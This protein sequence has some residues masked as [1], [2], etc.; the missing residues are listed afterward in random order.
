MKCSWLQIQH[1]IYEVGSKRGGSH[2]FYSP[3]GQQTTPPASSRHYLG[4]ETTVQLYQLLYGWVISRWHFFLKCKVLSHFTIISRR[5]EV[6]SLKYCI[7]ISLHRLEVAKKT[8][9][10]IS[11]FKGPSSES[12][13]NLLRVQ[14]VCIASS[15]QS[16]VL[17]LCPDISV[18]VKRSR[19]HSPKE[20][21]NK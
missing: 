17:M 18:W 21:Y 7:V 1:K 19:Q 20:K 12:F 5:P 4:W 10:W 8:P 6:L 3:H 15:S 2:K 14:S 11:N 9:K 16:A 13:T